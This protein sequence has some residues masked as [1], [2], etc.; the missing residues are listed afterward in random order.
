[1]KTTF[2]TSAHSPYDDRIFYHQAK[3]LV[4]NGDE[5]EIISSTVDLVK[6]VESI[7]LNCFY[8]N[9]LTKK[10]KVNAFIERLTD[11][12][13]DVVIC[14]GPIAVVAAW[15][16]RKYSSSKTK[17]VYDVTEWYPSKKNLVNFRFPVKWFQFIKLLL[18]NFGVSFYVDAFLFGEYYK[19]KPY[20][21]LFP[22]KPYTFLSYYPDLKYIPYKE[23]ALQ[24]D[25]LRLSYSGKI[26]FEKGFGSFIN[27]LKEL[28]DS[29]RQLKIELKI[30][31]WFDEKDEAECQR[32][33][34]SLSQRIRIKEYERQ[35]FDEF[36][37]LINDS[38]FFLDLRSD[39]LENQRCLP[40]KLFYYA[41]LGRPV[42]F[43]KL[44]A[45]RKEVEI[46][47]LGILV[48]P[49]DAKLV[50]RFIEICVDHPDLYAYYCNEA[51]H[52]AETKYN[53]QQIEPSFLNFIKAL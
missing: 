44:K 12:K 7:S 51:R 43:S 8:G 22:W 21:F 40:I 46:G 52:L 17:I 49:T 13:P 28:C 1:M 27:V 11:G 24:K 50:A 34:S 9:E 47:Y 30:I 18:F 39:D 5:V 36:L 4:S 38:D 53:W 37:E 35:D 26:S 45:I 29:N 15:Q 20:R 42:I 19:S 33:I 2:L 41:A 6:D 16:Y 14:S 25:F 3:S 31:G 23:P 48:P 32:L 10:E